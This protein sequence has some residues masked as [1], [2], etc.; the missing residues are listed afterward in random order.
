M[1]YARRQFH[2][3]RVAGLFASLVASLV[4]SFVTPAGHVQTSTEAFLE[5]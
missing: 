4:A 3:F 5:S 1:P 2:L